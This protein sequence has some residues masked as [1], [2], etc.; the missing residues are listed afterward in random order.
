MRFRIPKP[1]LIIGLL[2]LL[3]S[4]AFAAITVSQRPGGIAFP[5]WYGHSA[6]A[7]SS[8]YLAHPTLTANDTA[9]G[10]ATTDTLTN[11]TLTAPTVTT[12]TFASPAISGA[13]TSIAGTV[14][15]NGVFVCTLTN[16]TTDATILLTDADAL[17][18]NAGAGAAITFTMPE[19]STV[20]GREFKFAVVDA[21]TVN[22]DVD[23]ADLI[24]ALTNAAGDK[25]QNTGTAGNTIR[26]MAINTTNFVAVGQAYGTWSDAN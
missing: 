21:N 26:L 13:S 4:L 25:I 10:L 3:V 11:K 23:A 24:L 2:L 20:I 6:G 22:I 1:I 15:H 12:G 18:T 19:A 8:Y 14:D 5:Y 9:V 16:K 17:V 7:K